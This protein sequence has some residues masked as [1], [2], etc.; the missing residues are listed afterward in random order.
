MR[1]LWTGSIAFGLVNIPV[2]LFSAVRERA[3]DFDMLDR[4]DLSHIKFKR[5]NEKTG[6]EVPWDNIVK[7]YEIKGKYVVLTDED[8][9]SA[10]PEK[11]KTI[12]LEQFVKLSEID[13]IL[14]DAAY[15]L[16]PAKGGER[17]FGLLQEV[18]D[19]SQRAGVG[20]FV[21]RNREKPVVVRPAQKLLILHTLRF[22]NEIRDPSEFEIKKSTPP[23]KELAMART[24]VEQM[25]DNF[26]IGD[27]K[28]SYTAKLMRRIRAKASGKKLPAPKAVVSAPVHDLF[29]QLQ[30][31]LAKPK[32][33]GKKK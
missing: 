18:L 7:G 27:F 6:K 19:K 33:R 11:T 2:K 17:A 8:F 5:I 31:S 14:F 12:D 29:E 25:S 9:E 26:N 13:V 21:L 20:T 3:L 28:D 23:K 16:S 4:K 1:S 32:S 30:K 15:Y 22:A 24:L 10:S